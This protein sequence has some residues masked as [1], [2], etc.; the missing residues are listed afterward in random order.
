[1]DKMVFYDF[2]R[3]KDLF[4]FHL[5]AVF[6]KGVSC[7]FRMNNNTCVFQNIQRIFMNLLALFFFSK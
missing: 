6:F 5:C 2:G 7:F 1:M 4:A 3:E